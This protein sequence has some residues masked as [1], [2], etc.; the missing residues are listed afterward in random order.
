LGGAGWYNDITRLISAEVDDVD[1]L[2]GVFLEGRSLVRNTG[3]FPLA[4]FSDPVRVVV[5]YEY[6][7]TSI[8][9]NEHALVTTVNTL[10]KGDLSSWAQSYTATGETVQF[11]P[12]GF[13]YPP[14]VFDW[15]KRSK[16]FRMPGVA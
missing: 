1:V 10:V 13:V 11:P 7:N 14:A 2:A 6:G 8:E 16:G 15:L 12:G 9:A 3:S 4:S 5:E